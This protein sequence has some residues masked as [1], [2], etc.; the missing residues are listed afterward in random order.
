MY[1]K[2]SDEILQRAE[3]Y[4]EGWDHII[5]RHIN[6]YDEN[7]SQFLTRWSQAEIKELILS[8]LREAKNNSFLR[9][10]RLFNKL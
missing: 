2:T 3:L 6:W 4:Q 8:C 7:R 9:R 5:E 1:F 10:E